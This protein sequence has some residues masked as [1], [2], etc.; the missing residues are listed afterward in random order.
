MNQFYEKIDLPEASYLLSCLVMQSERWQSCLKQLI[1]TILRKPAQR[2][3]L[4]KQ[5]PEEGY[6]EQYGSNKLFTVTV[7]HR[8]A[9]Q[10]EVG[11]VLWSKRW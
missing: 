5:Q 2:G 10:E 3:L 11:I 1:L 4:A 8:R 7:F 9:N 6:V